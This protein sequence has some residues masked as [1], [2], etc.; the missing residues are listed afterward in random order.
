MIDIVKFR[1]NIGY[2]LVNIGLFVV[3]IY[4]SFCIE[5]WKIAYQVSI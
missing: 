1:T 4:D 2:Q 5:I 3:D